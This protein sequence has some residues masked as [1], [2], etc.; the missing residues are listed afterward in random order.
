M[1]LRVSTH[2]KLQKKALKAVLYKKG[3]EVRG[4]SVYVLL[5]EVSKSYKIDVSS[6]IDDAILL[7]KHYTP[8]RYPNLHPGM[9]LLAHKLYTKEDAERCLSTAM[10]VI[11]LAK[12]L[13]M[14]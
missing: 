5:M 2:N 6:Y 9:D 8:P 1:Q 13:L 12:K 10:N 14:N 7:D 11:N 3:I 4:H